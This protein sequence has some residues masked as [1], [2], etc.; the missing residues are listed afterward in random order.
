MVTMAGAGMNG[1]SNE[2]FD[3]IEIGL[4]AS[5]I[6]QADSYPVGGVDYWGC[7]PASA[8]AQFSCTTRK[9]CQYSESISAPCI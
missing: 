7:S 2:T 4:A 8:R 9:K 3:F 1:G 5:M 6:D